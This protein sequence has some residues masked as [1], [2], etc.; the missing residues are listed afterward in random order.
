MNFRQLTY[1]PIFENSGLIG[2]F[3]NLLSAF[4]VSDIVVGTYE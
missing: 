2:S 1:K 3:T 4:H